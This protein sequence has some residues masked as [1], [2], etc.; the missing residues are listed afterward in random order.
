M[1][2]MRPAVTLRRMQESDL[3][4]ALRLTQAQRWSHQF[5]DW[6]LHFE[7]GAGW[8]ACDGAGTVVGTILWWAY[9]AS[10]GS[11]GLVVVDSHQQGRGI[12]RLLMDAVIEVA[13]ARDLQLVATTAGI[14]LYQQCGFRAIRAIAQH[15]G[16]ARAPADI[17]PPAGIALR[18]ATAADLAEVCNLDARAAGADRSALLHAVFGIGSG[19][20]AE[21]DARICGFALQRPAGTGI[22]IGPVIA[23]D[24]QLATALIS[25]QLRSCRAVARVDA[26]ASAALLTE[27]LGSSG[28]PCVDR[29]TQMTRTAEPPRTTDTAPD[30]APPVQI[31]GLASQAF[32]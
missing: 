19:V 30:A 5:S 11:V 4:S 16:I 10:L 8:V 23:A 1:P 25:H 6:Q 21:R 18:A 20:V 28:L 3:R 27:W 2:A 13:G 15:Q 29:V 12:G 7:L 9:G 32:G 26:P 17:A 31:F 24:Q 22:T 14:K